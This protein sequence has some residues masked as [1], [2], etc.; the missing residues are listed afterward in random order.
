MSVLSYPYP[1]RVVS[2]AVMENNFSVAVDFFIVQNYV[3]LL[4]LVLKFEIAFF[5]KVYV[6][7][8][9]FLGCVNIQ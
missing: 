3:L 7:N 9:V 8:L 6:Q 5:R 1:G 4:V 2:S